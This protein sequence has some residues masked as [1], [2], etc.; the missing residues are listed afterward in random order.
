MQHGD[1]CEVLKRDKQQ[2][3]CIIQVLLII[4]LISEFLLIP[5]LLEHIY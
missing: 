1:I 5:Y 2:K 4:N 3:K